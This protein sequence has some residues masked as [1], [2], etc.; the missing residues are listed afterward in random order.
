MIADVRVVGVAPVAG[1]PIVHELLDGIELERRDLVEW[2]GTPAL[3]AALVIRHELGDAAPVGMQPVLDVPPWCTF[4]ID[5]DREPA[6]LFHGIFGEVNR[7]L[8]CEDPGVTYVVRYAAR[9]L[10]PVVALQSELAAFSFALSARGVGLIA[11]SCAFV[12][13]AG[14]GVLCP[15][16]SGTGKTTL[17]RL[18]AAHCAD[19]R[20]LT[21]DRAIVTLV[22]DDVRVWGSPWPGA[23]RIAGT[24]GAPLRTIVF[25]RHDARCTAR[26]VSPGDAFR[27]IVN[28]LSMPLWEPARCGRA[29]EIVDAIASNADLVEIGYP[30][31]SDGAAWLI[32]RIAPGVALGD[33]R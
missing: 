30:P 10:E 14:D 19:V 5:R 26:R 23:A 15:G 18:L 7:L 2:P 1:I 24:G 3:G 31:T 11:H 9:P 17:A 33:Q 8:A 25:I 22:D 29:L 20:L 28:T 6:S 32:G 12:T 27:R 16:I 13:P 21:D 4:H